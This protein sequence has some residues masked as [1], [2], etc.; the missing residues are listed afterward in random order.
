MPAQVLES[1]AQ[2]LVRRAFVLVVIG[3]IVI[4]SAD[5][6]VVVDVAGARVDFVRRTVR[7]LAVPAPAVAAS[8]NACLQDQS[9]EVAERVQRVRLA[10]VGQAGV[11]RVLLMR[12]RELSASTLSV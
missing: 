9:A 7:S 11:H 5:V 1:L 8:W 6:V 12:H 4:L 2:Q 10:V 3:V